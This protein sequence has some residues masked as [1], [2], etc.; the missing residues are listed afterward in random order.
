MA[1]I[2]TGKSV[3]ELGAQQEDLGG[4]VD[5]QQQHDQGARRA[6]GRRYVAAADVERD[7]VLAALEQ[8]RCDP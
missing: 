6:V 3:G 4:V 7:Q 2:A 8:H 1:A 5:P